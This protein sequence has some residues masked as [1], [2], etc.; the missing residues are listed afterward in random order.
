MLAGR[1]VGQLDQ[2]GVQPLIVRRGRGQL[3]LDL[4]VLDDPTGGGVDQEHPARLQPSSGHHLGRVHVQHSGLAGQH[5]Q[6]VAGAPPPARPQS[7]AVEHRTGQGA[8]GEGDA[9]RTVPGLHQAGVELVEGPLG[10]VHLR[11]VLPCLRNHHQHRVRQAAPGQVQQLQHLVEVGRVR[12]VRV[13][14]REHPAQIARQQPR[15]QQRLPGGHPV[16]VAADGVEL[17]V[18]GHQPV[19]VRQ[20]PGGEGVGGEP[21][22]HQGDRG[23]QPRVVQVAEVGPELVRREHSFVDKSPI[24]QRREV[25]RSAT[26]AGLPLGLLAQAPDRPFQL[27]AG[28]CLAGRPRR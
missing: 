24:G 13:T 20:R 21:G 27:H 18:V 2:P 22:M 3:G 4:F 1:Q 7:I 17:A 6:A 14:D 5:H 8:V 23:A 10:R 12:A 26:L 15:T 28:Q 16:L 19:R 25:C 11:V 9:G